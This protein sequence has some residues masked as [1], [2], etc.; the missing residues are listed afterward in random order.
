MSLSFTR[1]VTWVGL[2]RVNAERNTSMCDY[3]QFALPM[4]NVTRFCL[5]FD[6]CAN[7][8]LLTWRHWSRLQIVCCGYLHCVDVS[9]S[10][11]GPFLQS[12]IW[13]FQSQWSQ[14]QRIS[15]QIFYYLFLQ[16]W[17]YR[18]GWLTRLYP[19]VL[20]LFELQTS[21]CMTLTTLP[22]FIS[23]HAEFG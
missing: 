17:C 23:N 5:S 19:W 9:T 1:P 14:D 20:R 7:H 11:S 18:S 8:P 4:T 13:I 2:G 21:M 12:T 6:L 10:P 3:G 15:G 22:L 16:T